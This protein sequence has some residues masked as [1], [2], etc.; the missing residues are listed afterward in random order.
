MLAEPVS[1]YFMTRLRFLPI[2]ELRFAK[3]FLRDLYAHLARPGGHAYENLSLQSNPP[4]MSTDRTTEKGE[5]T[6]VCRVG[7]DDIHIEESEA[8]IDIEGFVEIVDTVLKAVAA[9]KKETAPIFAQ[10]CVFRCVVKPGSA[11]SISLLAGKVSNVLK[12]IGPFER[13]PQFFGVRFRF[14][15][16]SMIQEGA[17]DGEETVEEK[18]D[19]VSVRFETW[20]RDVHQVWIEVSATYFFQDAINV[21]NTDRIAHNIRDAHQFLTEKCVN[22]LNQFDDLPEPEEGDNNQAEGEG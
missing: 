20:S 13:P 7:A 6:S 9:V 11:N 22:F 4:R 12:A 17:D 18:H 14:P 3:S 16:V 15:P 1:I 19:F 8:E 21:A 10:A 5:S 2:E